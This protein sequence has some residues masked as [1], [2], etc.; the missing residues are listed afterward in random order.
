MVTRDVD[1]SWLRFE[2]YYTGRP[3]PH[4]D[5]VRAKLV[6]LAE[7]WEPEASQSPPAVRLSRCAACGK[8][9]YRPLHMWLEHDG[10]KKEMHL[11][12]RCGRRRGLI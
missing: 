9:V 11:H 2:D 4:P 12:R 6:A 7:S 8:R 3:I 10:W 1:T 5:D